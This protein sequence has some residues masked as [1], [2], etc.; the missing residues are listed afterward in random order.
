MILTKT[1][2]LQFT[3]KK[4]K[5]LRNQYIGRVEVLEK[6]KELFLIPELEVM[7]V[8]QVAEFY[9]VDPH[10]ITVCYQRNK[11]EVDEDGVMHYSVS[12]FMER[13][14]LSLLV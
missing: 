9:E 5:E 7:T 10:K 13:K 8:K 3:Q 14:T 1:N 4:E 11:V 6:V 2:Q 12:D